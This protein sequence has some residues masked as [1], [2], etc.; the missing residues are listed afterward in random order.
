[1]F[2]Y[3]VS[4]SISHKTWLIIFISSILT[5]QK[6][7]C[8]DE[9]TRYDHILNPWLINPAITGSKNNSFNFYVNKQ[10][11]GFKGAP[12]FFGFNISGRLAPYD[13]YTNRMHLNKTR[14]SSLGRVGLGASLVS[15]RNGPFVYSGLKLNYSYH[16]QFNKNQLSFGISNDFD[17]YSINEN[18]MDPLVPNDPMIQGVYRSKILYNPGFGVLY[19]NS[20]FE[21]G[22]AI[23]NIFQKD[24]ILKQDY[25]EYPDNHCTFSLQGSYILYPAG[26][27]SFE[28]K[29]SLSTNK[30]IDL[31]Y[32][33]SEAIIYRED[34]KFSLT[35][36]SLGFFVAHFG[37]DIGK[38]NFIY[39]F[40]SPTG[41]LG[42]YIYGS[43]EI[44][45][46]IRF[47]EYVFR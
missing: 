35:Y 43:H 38:Y 24:I 10:W 7:Y 15:D 28:S 30:F 31:F 26:Y 8:Q 2:Q 6:M 3:I 44:S 37:I 27:F 4:K 23:N 42:K 1:M 34:Y 41:G 5:W 25:F 9:I 29:G 14:Y 36:N 18:E 40:S 21:I 13:F 45:I 33:F 16:I 20:S 47:G 46:G 11:L 22:F 32:Y 19:Y 39:G 12:Y 17:L